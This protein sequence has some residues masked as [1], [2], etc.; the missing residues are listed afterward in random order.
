LIPWILTGACTAAVVALLFLGH[1]RGRRGDP[2]NFINAQRFSRH[3]HGPF[4][5][6]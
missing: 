6:L 3:I 5:P 1:R 4:K 2:M